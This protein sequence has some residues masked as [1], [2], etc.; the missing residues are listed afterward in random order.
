MKVAIVFEAQDELSWA[1]LSPEGFLR[2]YHERMFDI[3]IDAMVVQQQYKAEV[4]G[5]F[6][7]GEPQRIIEL[8]PPL[9]SDE[10]VVA[11]KKRVEKEA[12][13]RRQQH[14]LAVKFSN[15]FKK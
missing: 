2:A 11:E 10:I 7:V 5:P 14:K 13:D 4:Q 6:K 15:K 9:L 1:N 12:R 3:K 8:V